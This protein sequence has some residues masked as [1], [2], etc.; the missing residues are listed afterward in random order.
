MQ[1]TRVISHLSVNGLRPAQ[2]RV[3][4][5]MQRVDP[6]GVAVRWLR[7]TPRRQYSESGALALWHI[8]GNHKLIQ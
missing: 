4:E 8:D 6:P 7:L 1:I 3:R 2:L 5:G